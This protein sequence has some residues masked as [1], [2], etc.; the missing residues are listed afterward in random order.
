MN[1]ISWRLPRP[2]FAP[3]TQ[4]RGSGRGVGL[5]LVCALLYG[6]AG[7]VVTALP[8]EP[9]LWS[10]LLVALGLHLWAI[11]LAVPS[12]GKWLS[13]LGQGILQLVSVLGITLPLAIAL[14]HLGSDQLN[15]I[16]I[17]RTMGEVV[18]LSLVAVGL[19]ILCRWA[20]D[21][22]WQRLSDRMS[23]RQRH[24]VIALVGILGLALGG[25]A[26]LLIS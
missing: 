21:G 11:S 9:W 10:I 20:T 2:R 15:G 3:P 5:M 22:L 24:G 12:P 6:L 25:G 18:V 26:G 1:R 14:N 13:R 19:A 8:S 16:T 7:F 23:R 17:L 4:H